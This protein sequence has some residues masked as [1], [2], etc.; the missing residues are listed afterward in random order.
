MVRDERVA[1]VTLGAAMRSGRGLA[2]SPPGTPRSL[3]HPALAALCL[4]HAD[5]VVAA[6]HIYLLDKH[7][8]IS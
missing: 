1:E 4:G 3:L 7:T 2:A 6:L 8:A 5:G